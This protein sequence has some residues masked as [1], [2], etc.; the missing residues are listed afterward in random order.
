MLDPSEV[1]R[2]FRPPVGT[3]LGDVTDMRTWRRYRITAKS[4][5]LELCNCDAYAEELS[6]PQ[7]ATE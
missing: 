6:A 2:W 3:H 7:T 1:E 5:G 4:C